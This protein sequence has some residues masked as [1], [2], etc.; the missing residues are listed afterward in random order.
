MTSRAVLAPEGP[1]D[2]GV[3][4]FYNNHNSNAV[5]FHR[6]RRFRGLANVAWAR[7]QVGWGVEGVWVWVGGWWCVCVGGG[8]G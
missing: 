3:D 7:E 2:A 5:S 1:D 6:V 8:G 4:P